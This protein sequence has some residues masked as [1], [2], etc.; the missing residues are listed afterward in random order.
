MSETQ[1]ELMTIDEFLEI[2]SIGRNAFY[3]QTRKKLLK[4]TPLGKRIYIKRSDA[5][6]WMAALKA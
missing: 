3:T 2:Y 6:M 4:T 1:K 5:E